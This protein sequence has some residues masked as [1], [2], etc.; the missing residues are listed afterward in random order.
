METSIHPVATALFPRPFASVA[1]LMLP[2]IATVPTGQVQSV[3]SS[4]RPEEPARSEHHFPDH[5]RLIGRKE[6]FGACLL[7]RRALPGTFFLLVLIPMRH[8]RIGGRLSL[9]ASQ[10]HERRRIA[11]VPRIFPSGCTSIC[12][13]A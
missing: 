13:P 4:L 8:N 10:I 9:E 6:A 11:S 1:T 12:G 2:A 3:Q 5:A 7:L